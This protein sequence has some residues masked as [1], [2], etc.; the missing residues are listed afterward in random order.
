MTLDVPADGATDSDATESLEG[1]WTGRHGPH[2]L[3]HLGA[4]FSCLELFVDRR[5]DA[6][7]TGVEVRST[8]RGAEHVEDVEGGPVVVARVDVEAAREVVADRVLARERQLT[9]SEPV[10][11][12]AGAHDTTQKAVKMLDEGGVEDR[13]VED[14]D[15]LFEVLA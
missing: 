11:V 2:V 3:T 14:D 9:H 8:E 10:G 5:A 7:D 12:S 4:A 1:A 15:E 6:G 13:R